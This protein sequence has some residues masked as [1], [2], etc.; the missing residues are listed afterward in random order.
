MEDLPEVEVDATKATTIVPEG[1][2]PTESS[3]QEEVACDKPAS[4]PI[5]TPIASLNNEKLKAV[6]PLPVP[7]A[8]DLLGLQT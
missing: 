5:D 7:S 8:E 4:P 1:V 3:I 6:S 2:K